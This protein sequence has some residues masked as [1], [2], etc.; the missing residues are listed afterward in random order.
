MYPKLHPP[1]PSSYYSFLLLSLFPFPLSPFP[2]LQQIVYF[3]SSF[4]FVSQILHIVFEIHKIPSNHTL[5]G[6][7]FP[8]LVDTTLMIIMV[9]PSTSLI[10]SSPPLSSYQFEPA[11]LN[12]HPYS[13]PLLLYSIVNLVM[14]RPS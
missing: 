8:S 11:V 10:S 7:V 2:R 3:T 12:P 4:P 13:L 1:Y 14:Q 9:Y 6:P 5:S